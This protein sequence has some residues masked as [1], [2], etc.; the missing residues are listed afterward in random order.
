MGGTN[1]EGELIGGKT[2]KTTA[3]KRARHRREALLCAAAA[4]VVALS[5]SSAPKAEASP[6]IDLVEMLD[7]VTPAVGQPVLNPDTGL[8]ETVVQ[9]LANGIV[10]TNDNNVIVLADAVGETITLTH[11]DTTTKTNVS[12][13]YTV[14][15]VY[16]NSTTNDVDSVQLKLN[17]S[18]P[19][20]YQ[21]LNLVKN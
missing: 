13:T 15:K 10:L 3:A 21:T 12:N 2:T 11:Y 19:A 7:V 4:S 20:V 14:T 9:V 5:L 8:D 17:G 18:N 16:D 6:M 1:N